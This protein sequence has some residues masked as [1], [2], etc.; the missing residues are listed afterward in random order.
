[1]RERRIGLA[2]WIKHPR[3]AKNLRRFGTVHFVSK[4]LQYVSMYVDANELDDTIRTLEKMHFVLKVEKSY[5]HEIPTEYNNS[6]PDKAK[7]YDYQLEKTQLMALTESL[8][9]EVVQEK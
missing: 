4:R 7:E 1:M 8:T 6:K 5:R 2:V 9:A 3:L